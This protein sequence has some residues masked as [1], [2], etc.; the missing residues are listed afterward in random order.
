MRNRALIGLMLV[1]ATA[2]V[3][4]P[5]AA[6]RSC[7]GP[8]GCS[9]SMAVGATIVGTRIAP[10]ARMVVRPDPI[11]NTVEVVT[12]ANTGWVL[13]ISG[14]AGTDDGPIHRSGRGGT[15]VAS[16]PQGETPVVVATL[17]AS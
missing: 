4:A 3:A 1:A 10:A 14:A 9:L 15:A 12:A 17:A 5:L 13:S 11:H 8:H 16:L 6:Q 2:V 7:S